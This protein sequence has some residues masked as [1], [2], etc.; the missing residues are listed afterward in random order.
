[1]KLIKIVSLIFLFCN[2]ANG[3]VSETTRSE[4]ATSHISTVTSQKLTISTE[5]IV[6]T[7][8]VT[9]S[10]DTP[11]IENTGSSNATSM[12]TSTFR[13]SIKTDTANEGTSTTT[14]LPSPKNVK[15]R[16]AAIQKTNSYSTKNSK[17]H[18]TFQAQTQDAKDL[19]TSSNGGTIAIV[20]IV[21]ILLLI[22]CAYIYY[23]KYYQTRYT[24]L[25]NF[26][27]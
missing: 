24:F 9:N 27:R 21:I 4:A 23:K 25:H 2:V 22:I 15:N 14:S 10:S 20:V 18:S 3:D 11:V 5:S 16:T 13:E 8:I 6:H 26:V 12:D 17:I 1:M 19:E 7:S